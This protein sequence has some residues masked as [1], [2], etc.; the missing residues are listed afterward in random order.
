MTQFKILYCCNNNQS[1][2]VIIYFYYIETKNTRVSF[3][4]YYLER[5]ALSIFKTALPYFVIH[6]HTRPKYNLAI[7]TY[8]IISCSI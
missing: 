3:K 2:T 5:D 4:H 6:T 1:I 8:N 7:Y